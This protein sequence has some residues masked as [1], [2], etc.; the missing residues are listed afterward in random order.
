ME[1]RVCVLERNIDASGD[2]IHS[3][4]TKNSTTEAKVRPMETKINT[5]GKKLESDG[6]RTD[7]TK[8]S[9]EANSKK[10]DLLQSDVASSFTRLNLLE[11]EMQ[12]GSLKEKSK[13]KNYILS[14]SNHHRFAYTGVV[15]QNF[16]C[17]K[18]VT[19]SL[20]C[21][22]CMTRVCFLLL[23]ASAATAKGQSL[24]SV[25]VDDAFM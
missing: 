3:M 8:R 18:C 16:Y 14:V 6:H 4:E 7:F 12:T 2:K 24:I 5:T 13:L 15:L 25:I 9:A 22:V 1:T 11:S 21:Q 10:I 20:I 23:I 17:L 19:A